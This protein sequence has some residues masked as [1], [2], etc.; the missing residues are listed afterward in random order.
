MNNTLSKLKVNNE[1]YTPTWVWDCLK[2][3]IPTNKIIWEAFCCDNPNSKMSAE[4]LKKIGFYPKM[5]ISYF[6]YILSLKI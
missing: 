4:Y 2:Q 1:Y 3:Y 5:E 6:G